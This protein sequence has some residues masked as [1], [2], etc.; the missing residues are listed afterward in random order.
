MTT[1]SSSH[2]DRVNFIKQQTYFRE[3][4]AKGNDMPKNS[5]IFASQYLIL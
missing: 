4:V 2:K 3:N 1:L 5:R